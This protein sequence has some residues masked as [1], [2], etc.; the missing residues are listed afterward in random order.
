MTE[1]KVG[2][3]PTTDTGDL[4]LLTFLFADVRGYTRFTAEFGDEAAARLATRLADIA[5]VVAESHGG[6]VLELRGDE[7]LCVFSS[8]RRALECAV[9]LQAAFDQAAVDDATLPV[10]AGI[11]VDVGEAV[12]VKGGYRGSV[13][14][15]AARL[16]SLAGPGDIFATQ[17]VV[18]LARRIEGLEAI[19]RGEVTLKGLVAPVRILQIAPQ[20]KLAADLPP[21]QPVERTNPTNLP[22]EPTRFIGRRAEI[23][24]VCRILREPHTRLVTMTGPGGTGKTR[25]SV[26][27]GNAVL[28]EFSGGVFFVPLAPLADPGMV[29]GTIAAVLGVT[30]NA[31]GTLLNTLA[32][33]LRDWRGL[34]ILDNFEHVLDASAE[35]AWL[36]DDCHQLRVLVTSRMSLHVSREREYSVTPLA[37]PDSHRLPDIRSLLTY[38]AISLFVERAQAVRS[39]FQLTETNASAT[40]EICSW[41]DGLPLSIELAAAR[42]KLFPPDVLLPRLTHRLSLLTEGARDRPSRQQTLRATLDWSYRLLSE[43]VQTLLGRLSVFVGGCTYEAALAVCNGEPNI[44]LIEGLSSLVDHSLLRPEGEVRS[45]FVM[46]ETVREYAAERLEESENGDETR[47]QA[48]SFFLTWAEQVEPELSGPAQATWLERIDEEHDNL[49]T[50]LRWA[51]EQNEVEIGF[52]LASALWR[53]WRTRGLVAEGNQWAESLLAVDQR[54]ARP[55]HG[56]DSF[57]ARALTLTATF[58]F[59]QSGFERA[60]TLSEEALRLYR[61]ANDDDGAARALNIMGNVAYHGADHIG[62]TALYEESLALRRRV[63]DRSDIAMSLS[64]LSAVAHAQS[65]YARSAELCRE[66]LALF[67]EIGDVRNIAMTLSSLGVL[68]QA[69]GA[70]DEALHLLTESL[71]TRRDLGDPWG[72][73]ESLH[74]LA[75]AAREMGQEERALQLHIESFQLYW[76]VG[77]R[78]GYAE[79]L[80]AL[81]GEMSHRA[82]F[83]LAAQLLGAAAAVR[84]N[85]DAPMWTHGH[86]EYEQDRARAREGLGELAFDRARKE[87]QNMAHQELLEQLRQVGPDSDINFA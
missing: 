12:S 23:A 64:N 86:D 69:Q 44:D 5:T 28:S 37:L 48:V 57:R 67:R 9:S 46:L 84:T 61:E 51:V 72:V 38:D 81:A 59:T 65:D 8:A 30:E 15:V 58:A 26:E 10:K 24:E 43:D 13:L 60:R 83:R 85:I 17:A 2:R 35:I 66:S 19:D 55:L 79:S 27:V 53:Y 62:A 1:T 41:L 20:G 56:R 87:G 80:D 36:L 42:V 76:Q 74:N 6:R 54:N 25:L 47:R 82:K 68:C 39:D 16:C 22:D 49:R 18:Q 33:H 73:A 4:S 3:Q 11:G 45:R 29:V 50:A 78:F 21:L 71:Q 52:R 31:G 75:I 77:D 34:L 14:N 32:A 40:A 63:G 7:A 70:H